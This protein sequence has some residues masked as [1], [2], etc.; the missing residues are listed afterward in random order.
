MVVPTR[1]VSVEANRVRLNPHYP[2]YHGE[3]GA[4]LPESEW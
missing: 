2:D 3:Y 4:G 1:V